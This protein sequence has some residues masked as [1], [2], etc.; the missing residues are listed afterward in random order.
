MADSSLAG[1]FIR[2]TRGDNV[3]FFFDL[4]NLHQLVERLLAQ[5]LE[6]VLAE[7]IE[8]AFVMKADPVFDTSSEAKSLSL[9]DSL[10]LANKLEPKGR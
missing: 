9:E 1:R 6:V 3:F 10:F 4:P 7:F 2:F 5:V 8:R